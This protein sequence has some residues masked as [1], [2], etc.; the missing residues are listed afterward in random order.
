MISAIFAGE[1]T[2]TLISLS[3]KTF[4][5]SSCFSLLT[6]KYFLLPL[7]F[8]SEISWVKEN[9]RHTQ[10]THHLPAGNSFV[11]IESVSG[12]LSAWNE[13]YDDCSS[14]WTSFERDRTRSEKRSSLSLSF[15]LLIA[16]C[17]FLPSH[18]SLSSRRRMSFWLELQERPGKPSS[19]NEVLSKM[20]IFYLCNCLNVRITKQNE[21]SRDWSCLT[22]PK[23]RLVFLSWKLKVSL[24]FCVRQ[25]VSVFHSLPRLGKL[26]KFSLP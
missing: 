11:S 21:I 3:H 25:N 23:E 13:T 16:S 14:E 9:G 7:L 17:L 5:S 4:S 6:D 20:D 19:G 8:P 18:V 26:S 10:H 1:K 22:E 2:D 24:T 12:E 15:I